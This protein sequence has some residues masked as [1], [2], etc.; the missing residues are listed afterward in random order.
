[1][2]I[3]QTP[4]PLN[5]VLLPFLGSPKVSTLAALAKARQ[6][7]YWHWDELRFR[8]PPAGLSREDWWAA[9]KLKRVS[10]TRSIPLVDERRNPFGFT[11]PDMVTEL[12][13]QIDRDGGTLIEMPEPVTNP[14]ER[15]RYIV[16]SLMEEA[17]TS[18]QLEGAATTREVAKRML[19]ENRPPR[20]RSE[21]MILNNFNAMR[22]II[23]LK[24]E[25]MTRDLVMEVH[26]I[27]SENALDVPGAE[28][29][30]RRASED[31]SVG[32]IEGQI[33]HVPP[34]AGELPARME[35]MCE[36]ANGKSPQYFIHP[37]I[38]AIILHFWLAYDHPFVDGN[39]RT[40]RALFYWQMLHDGYW[41][42]EFLSISQILRK[43][44]AKYGLAFLHTETDGNDLTYFILHQ[45][46]VI[47]RSLL[48]L[49]AYVQRKSRE[50]RSC[51]TLLQGLSGLNHR[52]Q[53]ILT[54]AIRHPKATY[55]I[56]GHQARHATAYD[57]ARN[58]LLNLATRQ[59]LEQRKM[60]RAMVFVAPSD[61]EK[62]LGSGA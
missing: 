10:E 20:D 50:T 42:F 17:I 5:E 32:D 60:G 30:F 61:L 41:L 6:T 25:T 31:V 9:L 27:V 28:G 11:M 24:H 34:A 21:R 22:R 16:R 4:P 35:L 55:T 48:E 14:A 44:P 33:F 56:A 36:F 53:A 58:D 26:Q 47:R 37:V 1:M 23:E 29:R 40:A 12:L 15:D 52:Q 45:A 46:D 38:R 51:V 39:G 13:H 8:K 49:H 2:K 43:A 19:A 3:P 62:R 57:T 7:H 54:H 59:L 18:S